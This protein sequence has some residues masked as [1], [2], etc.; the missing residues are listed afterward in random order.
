MRSLFVLQ[1][2]KRSLAAFVAFVFLSAT[3]L[4][5]FRMNPTSE[6]WSASNCLGN[7]GVETRI[8]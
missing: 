1:T 4:V 3:A 5:T 6:H 7:Q 8:C 2:S